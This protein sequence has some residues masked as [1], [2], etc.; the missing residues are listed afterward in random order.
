VK[1]LDD[2]FSQVYKTLAKN[3]YMNAT[4]S[5]AEK[6]MDETGAA[7]EATARNLEKA[8]EWSGQELE[9]DAKTAVRASRDITSKLRQGT[10]WLA[11]EVGESLQALGKEIDDFGKQVE[12]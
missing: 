10:G 9:E 8:A 7:L 5:W 2:A 1:E 4:R 11:S 12:Q 6:N 3:E